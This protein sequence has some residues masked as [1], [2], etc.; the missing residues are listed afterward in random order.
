MPDRWSF[1]KLQAYHTCPL[2]FKLQYMDELPQRENA[3]AQFGTLCHK[4][5]EEEAKGELFPFELA[6][7]YRERYENEITAAFP[8]FPKGMEERYYAEGL[9]FFEHYG[10]VEGMPLLIEHRFEVPVGGQLVSGVIDLAVEDRGGVYDIIDYKSKASK[11]LDRD[12]DVFRHQLYIYAYA[13]NELLGRLPRDLMF[14]LFREGT[15]IGERFAWS[16]M[17]ET[18][19]WIDGMVEEINLAACSGVW[20][21][22][23]TDYFCRFVC[24]VRDHCPALQGAG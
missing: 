4:L 23:R 17:E 11:S 3:F 22:K 9:T 15:A 24:G 6:D 7:E 8:P 19:A 1:T 13:A 16:R 20:S 10:G 18:I 21:A 2:F 5:L 12:Y 14:I